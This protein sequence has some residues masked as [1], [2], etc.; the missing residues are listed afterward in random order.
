MEILLQSLQNM[1]N[2]WKINKSKYM[3]S[4]LFINSFFLKIQ[5]IHLVKSQL[6]S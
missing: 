4:F 3:I 1:T 6:V 2:S 5:I